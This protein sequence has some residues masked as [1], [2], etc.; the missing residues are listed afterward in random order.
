MGEIGLG[1]FLLLQAVI[2]ATASFILCFRIKNEEIRGPLVGMLC[3][4]G[5]ILIASY[6]NM[7][8]FQYPNGPIIYACLTLVFMGTYFDQQYS[9]DHDIAKA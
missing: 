5:G 8:Y 7:V 3:G 9:K 1:V 2:L 6:G 4:C